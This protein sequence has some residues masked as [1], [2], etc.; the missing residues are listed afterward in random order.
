MSME[1]TTFNAPAPQKDIIA[2]L[3]ADRRSENTKRAYQKDLNDFFTTM[4]GGES[5]PAVINQFLKMERFEA[6][7]VA[8]QYK[9]LMIERGLSEAT[10]NRRLAALRSLVKYAKLIGQCD[11]SLEDIK[12]EKVQTYRDVSGISVAQMADMLK[13]PDREKIGRAHV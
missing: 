2:A 8:L 4:T 5:T 10:I 1:L 11:W 12:G 13:V 7:K 9:A 6:V 3:L